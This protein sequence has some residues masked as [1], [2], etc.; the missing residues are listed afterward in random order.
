LAV[1]VEG[2]EAKAISEDMKRLND[3]EVQARLNST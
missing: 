1:E 3:A 2:E